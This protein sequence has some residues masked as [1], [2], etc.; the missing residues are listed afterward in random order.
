MGKYLPQAQFKLSGLVTGSLTDS[1]TTATLS[2]PPSGAKL[3]MYM[4]L[5]P[6]QTDEELTKIIDV[7]GSNVTIQRGINN[8]GVGT[9]HNA[10]ITYEM[11]ISSYAWKELVDAVENGYLTEPT[12]NAFAKVDADTFTIAGVDRTDYYTAGRT[13]RLNGSVYATVVSSSFSSNTTVNISG[14]TV[15]TTVTSI[16]LILG[17]KGGQGALA[18]VSAIQNAKH[19]YG[20]DAGSTDD[21]EIDLLP[22]PSAYTDGM[23]VT[24][25]PNTENTG[26]STLNVNSLGAKDI[27]KSKDEDLAAGDIKEGQIVT[28]IYDSTTGDF[29]LQSSPV[30]QQTRSVPL[31]LKLGKTGTPAEGTVGGGN[32]LGV[33]LDKASSEDVW[34]KYPVPADWVPGTEMTIEWFWSMA[35]VTAGNVVIQQQVGYLRNGAAIPSITALLNQTQ[36]VAVPTSANEIEKTAF[37]TFTPTAGDLLTFRML[38]LGGDASDTA[39]EDMGLSGAV[40]TYTSQQ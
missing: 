40:L 11:V 33:L 38:R 35:S 20:V 26:A 22:A 14:G 32:D 25:K 27:K 30:T 5:S 29:M 39:N 21:Y 36:T 8:G 6:G 9:P 34:A 31:V 17:P 16:E 15:P 3:P 18:L 24:F 10:N 2:S 4:L 19:T 37:N 12:E 13:I 23:L 1:A 28:V 7:S